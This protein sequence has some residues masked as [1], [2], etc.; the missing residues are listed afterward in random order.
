MKRILVAAVAAGLSAMTGTMAQGAGAAPSG[1]SAIVTDIAFRDIFTSVASHASVSSTREDFES[2][3]LQSRAL[4]TP[5]ATTS[6]M[7]V[8]FTYSY[9]DGK[10]ADYSESPGDAGD[11]VRF[12]ASDFSGNAAYGCLTFGQARAILL[13]RGWTWRS[14]D[15]DRGETIGIT[16]GRGGV[17]MSISHFYVPMIVEYWQ[18]AAAAQ[19]Q[20]KEADAQI[21]L[22]EKIKP[23]SAAFLKTCV[24]ISSV[25]F[26]RH[27]AS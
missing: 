16:Y 24:T 15:N 14:D 4:R 1:T 10:G 20:Q 6:T 8:H 7:P 17:R 23:R 18:G 11:T 19:D 13:A 21:A 27:K 5:G 26:T 3:A 22:R 2:G 12:E 9:S 25:A